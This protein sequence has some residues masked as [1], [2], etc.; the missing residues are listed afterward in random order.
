MRRELEIT[1][2]GECLRLLPDRA[3]FW[4]SQSTL[5]VADVHLGKAA[6]FRS[7]GVPIP[8]GSTDVTLGRLSEL[9]VRTEARRL[10]VLGDLWHAK[11]G[12]TEDVTGK[13]ARWRA[14][15]EEV[16]MTL[17]EG[18]HDLRSG[19]LAPEWDIREVAEPTTLGPFSLCHYPETTV[20]NGYRLAGHLHPGVLLEGRGKQSLRLACF[21]FGAEGAILPAFGEFTG[22]AMI[23]PEERD[24]VFVV[25]QE[26]V[27]RVA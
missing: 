12:R 21:L 9:L 22:L 26:R 3:L 11:A 17:V 10:V 27:I 2:R 5:F 20:E 6:S 8:A 1:V 18:N 16:E 15:H 24:R 4:P 23:Q 25:T 7:F 14:A 13:F 19:K